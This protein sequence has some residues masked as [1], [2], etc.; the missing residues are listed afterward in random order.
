M[1]R[2]LR[3]Y[4]ITYETTFGT[5][6]QPV[7]PKYGNYYGRGRNSRYRKVLRKKYK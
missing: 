3:M 6:E 1:N 4:W 2:L 5:L 7:K